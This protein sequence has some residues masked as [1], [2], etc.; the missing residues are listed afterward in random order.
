MIGSWLQSVKNNY[1]YYAQRGGPRVKQFSPEP[2]NDS[3]KRQHRALKMQTLILASASPYR[4]I[5]LKQLG[6]PFSQV[7]AAIDETP[8]HGELATALCERLAREKAARIAEHHPGAVVIGADQVVEVAGELL[9]KPGTFAAARAQLRKQSGATVYFHSGCAAAYALPHED[10]HRSLKKGSR[11]ELHTAADNA[12]Q[13][14]RIARIARIESAVNT[15]RVVF[16][17][18]SDGQIDDYLL[19]DQPYDCAGSFKSECLGISLCAA[20]YSDDPSSLVGL[21]LIT[22][23]E[24]LA[25]IG[26]NSN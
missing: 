6:L 8:H 17:A 19:R 1:L 2:C 22:T 11:E 23:G 16:K 15:T 7:P 25:K 9:G 12:L 10:S 3:G 26:Y 18:L 13:I 5:Q 21:P 4:A 20:I 14:T 24:L